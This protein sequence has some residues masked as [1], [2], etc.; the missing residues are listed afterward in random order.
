MKK[1]VLLALLIALPAQAQTKTAAESPER[2]LVT[3][4]DAQIAMVKAA[5]A[6][7]LKDPEA[8]RFSRIKA[9][10]FSSESKNLTV[11]G[12][13]NA[14]YGY[15]GDVGKMPFMILILNGAMGKTKFLAWDEDSEKKIIKWCAKSGIDLSTD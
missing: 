3:L 6:D 14:K 2:V 13:I 4:T 9:S 10:G 5:V 7:Q 1:I 11:C 8:S 15:G 12:L